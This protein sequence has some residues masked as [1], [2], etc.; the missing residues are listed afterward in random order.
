[1]HDLVEL[2]KM[3][4]LVKRHGKF[5]RW[6]YSPEDKTLGHEASGYE[7][8]LRDAAI[9][10]AAM[11]DWIIQVASKPWCTAEDVGYLVAAFTVL[12]DPQATLCSGGVERKA[13]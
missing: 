9:S 8:D 7:V 11:L 6:V 1:M 2:T 5:G 3:G 10:S 13:K 12:I 4:H